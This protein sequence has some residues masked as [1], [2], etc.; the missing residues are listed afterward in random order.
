MNLAGRIPVVRCHGSKACARQRLA[1]SSTCPPNIRACLVEHN[2]RFPSSFALRRTAAVLHALNVPT[3]P[4]CLRTQVL[5]RHPGCLTP[6]L[7]VKDVLAEHFSGMGCK[8]FPIRRI[9]VFE[10]DI[11][12]PR[13]PV[14]FGRAETIYRSTACALPNR[15]EL[16]AGRLRPGP[17]N[18]RLG[19]WRTQFRPAEGPGC[20]AGLCRR[21]TSFV[22]R[23]HMSND[24][25]DIRYDAPLPM[26]LVKNPM[27]N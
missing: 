13:G 25:W 10:I 27:K 19:S 11:R 20:L 22:D 2:R 21:S 3:F 16:R 17:R 5:V 8:L 7:D 24:E 15:G 12:E 9:R 1:S 4:A 6:K 14:V 26:P 23:G 18:L